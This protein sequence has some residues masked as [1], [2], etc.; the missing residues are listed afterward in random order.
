MEIV[1]HAI[2]KISVGNWFGQK[3][4]KKTVDLLCSSMGEEAEDV[5]ARVLPVT[6]VA[7]GE[8]NPR[9]NYDTVKQRLNY[10]F[11]AKTNVIY[12]RYKSNAP[13]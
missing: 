10:H 3:V 13:L 6:K 11:A 7:V 4:G 5:L 8:A 9:E 1:N 2:Q 12:K